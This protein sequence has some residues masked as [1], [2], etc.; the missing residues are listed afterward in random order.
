[1]S[2][3]ETVVGLAAAI[4]ALRAELTTAVDRG[5]EEP[6][7]FRLAPVELT[8]QAAVTTGANGKIGW[9]VLGLGGHREAATTHTLK[10]SL[11]PVWRTTDGK[12]M[13]NFTITSSAEAGDAFGPQ[14]PSEDA[15][16]RSPHTSG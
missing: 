10:L 4:E 14:A 12:E 6:M 7:R 15:E 8:V 3:D 1:M 13:S 2:V 11:A 5:W 16:R 9:S